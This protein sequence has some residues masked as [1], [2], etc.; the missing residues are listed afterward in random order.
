MKRALPIEYA[1]LC[2]AQHVT[3]SAPCGK[4]DGPWGVGWCGSRKKAVLR[5][6]ELIKVTVSLA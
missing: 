1:L 5:S 3:L 2:T 4:E 6:G